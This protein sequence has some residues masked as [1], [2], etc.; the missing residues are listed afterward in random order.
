M[1]DIWN[2]YVNFYN[3]KY[4]K[5]IYIKILLIKKE[6]I[7][8]YIILSSLKKEKWKLIKIKGNRKEINDTAL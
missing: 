1:I 6:S 8:N 7:I 2:K 5:L 3:L 4:K